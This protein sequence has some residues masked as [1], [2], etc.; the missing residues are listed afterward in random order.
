MGAKVV[1]SGDVAK[2]EP[3]MKMIFGSNRYLCSKE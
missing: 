3:E 1:F 2:K